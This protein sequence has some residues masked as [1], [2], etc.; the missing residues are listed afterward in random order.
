MALRFRRAIFLNGGEPGTRTNDL[1]ILIKL[2]IRMAIS[3]DR[4]PGFE[5]E[6]W[7]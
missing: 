3:F 6:V 1:W 5:L 4:L 7:H 2:L